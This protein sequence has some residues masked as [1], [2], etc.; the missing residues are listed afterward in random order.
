[1]Q[2]DPLQKALFCE[3]TKGLKRAPA[4]ESDLNRK[5]QPANVGAL[6]L[7][8]L[9]GDEVAEDHEHVE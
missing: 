2:K 6:D 4:R 5:K 8:S 1:V 9:Y 7:G 3:D